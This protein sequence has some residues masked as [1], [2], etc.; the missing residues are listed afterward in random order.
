MLKWLQLAT[1][2]TNSSKIITDSEDT[3]FNITQQTD[4]TTAQNVTVNTLVSLISR[5]GKLPYTGTTRPDN[6]Y[7][8]CSHRFKVKQ[9]IRQTA[10]TPDDKM[11]TIAAEQLGLSPT[12]L[13]NIVNMITTV[14]TK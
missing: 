9:I 8:S 12:Q 10:R 2:V 7:G 4:N 6:R 11:E 3:K 14:L 1:S 13:S 5:F